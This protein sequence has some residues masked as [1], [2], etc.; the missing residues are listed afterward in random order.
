MTSDPHHACDHEHHDT[1]APHDHTGHDHAGHDQHGH[2][3]HGHGDCDGHSH[4]FGFGH[5]HVHAPANF[6]TAFAI[7]IALN[8]AYVAGEA[9]WGV[10]AHSLSL[11]AD[12]GHNLSDVLG[13][14]AAWL[15]QVLATRPAS[16][17]FTYGLRRSTILSALA[18]AT[19]LL[20]VTGGI[21]WEAALRLFSQQPVQGEIVSW[22][23]LVGIAVNA[24]TALLFMKGASS[25]LNI[26]GAFLHMASDAVMAF[27]VVIAGLLIS[28][29]G[30]TIIDPIMSLIV[31]VS[32]VVGTWSLLRNSLDL[33]LDAVPAGIDPNAV[34]TALL[35]LDGVSGLH[36]LHIWA[37]STTDTA[38]TVHLVCDVAHPV[39]ADRLIVRASELLRTRF[40]IAHP[41]FQLETPSS[42]CDTHQP[43]C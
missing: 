42:V 11:L 31:S 33:A 6:G 38:L 13:L 37:M 23:A 36:H 28:F 8:T 24:V 22:V 26:R 40:D 25:D 10:W 29:T 5:Q 9:L 20:L 18:N 21:I 15:A 43:C 27:S 16:T 2:E 19:I 17:R 41:T 12:A 3:D 32:I 30:Y 35:S 7:G 39:S 34:Q 1:A 14:A 4:G